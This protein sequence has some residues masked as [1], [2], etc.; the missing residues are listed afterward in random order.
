MIFGTII[1][2][3]VGLTSGLVFTANGI[4][5][6][7]NFLLTGGGVALIVALLYGTIGGLIIGDALENPPAEDNCAPIV[8]GK[9]KK[10]YG[11]RLFRFFK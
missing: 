4:G 6:Q 1:L 7:M 3:F 11:V 2:G 8:S 9:S 5:K 10:N